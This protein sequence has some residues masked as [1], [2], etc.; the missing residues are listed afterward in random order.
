MFFKNDPWWE[1]N[2]S[3]FWDGDVSISQLQLA[4][5]HNFR[6]RKL[7]PPSNQKEKIC[8][9]VGCGSGLFSE[10][11]IKKGYDVIGTDY[12]E[13]AI[14]LA[15]ERGINTIQVDVEREKIPFENQ[16]FDLIV[17]C[18]VIEHIKNPHNMLKEIHR[19]LKD[20]GFFVITTPNIAWWYLRLKMLFGIWGVIEPDHI[21]FFTPRS[22]KECLDFFGFKV[23]KVASLFNLPRLGIRELPYGHS[24]SY[25][26]GFQ[27]IKKR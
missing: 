17:C 13:R 7:I 18:E 22:L 3:H 2:K 5:E 20:D 15:K 8:L 4:K 26:F 14:K 27:C 21:R 12:D 23:I 10:Q 6:I 16:T 24:I 9:D 25:N 19:V 11:I 1:I